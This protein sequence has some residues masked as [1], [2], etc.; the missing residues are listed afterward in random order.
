MQGRQEDTRPSFRESSKVT[1]E[2]HKMCWIPPVELCDPLCS[3]LFI[4]GI[5]WRQYAKCLW[6]GHPL[7]SM[8]PVLWSLEKQVWSISHVLCTNTKQGE[9]FFWVWECGSPLERNPLRA[10]LEG[11]MAA[12]GLTLLGVPVH[13]HPQGCPHLLT[14][15]KPWSL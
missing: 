3:E 15:I 8:N 5:Q 4:R 11:R 10:S 2:S 13:F 12:S 6:G 1:V 14:T 9:P 7:V